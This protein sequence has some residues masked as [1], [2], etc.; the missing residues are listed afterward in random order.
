M[1]RQRL[2]SEERMQPQEK[3]YNAVVERGYHGGLTEQEFAVK[4]VA[5]LGEEFGE[6]TDFV[7]TVIDSPPWWTYHI[8]MMAQDCR[9]A[10]DKMGNWRNVKIDA[11]NSAAELADVAVVVLLL[12]ETISRITGQPF[13]VIQAAVEKAEKDV[14]RGVRHE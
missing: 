9:L 3:V 10:F 11:G 14:E 13:D 8:R 12:S 1:L 5:K 6:L 4:Q 2:E 7:K